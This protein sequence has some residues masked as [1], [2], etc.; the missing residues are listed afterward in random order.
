MNF[1]F[2]YSLFLVTFP[3]FLKSLVRILARFEL[4]KIFS[5]KIYLSMKTLTDFRKMVET[6]VDPRLRECF[7]K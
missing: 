5:S 7:I 3:W 1:F 2:F 4:G 6:G